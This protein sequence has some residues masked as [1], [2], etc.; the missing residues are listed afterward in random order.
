MKT[1]IELMKGDITKVA[2]DAIV[3]AA[4]TSL[5]GGGGVDGA[6]HRAAGPE[7]LAECRTLGGCETGQAKIT[8][9]Y[10]LAARYVIHAVGPVWHGGSRKEDE[11]L[12][13]CYRNALTL[14]KEH[15]LRSI[16]FPSIST[17]AYRFPIEKA[18]GIALST[19]KDILEKDPGAIQKVI[20]VLFSDQDLAVYTRSNKI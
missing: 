15:S 2:A 13:S 5:L 8:K 1:Q 4:N 18:A 17:G 19:V 11:L 10:R 6:I 14:A 12:A 3:N 20:F 16:A 7:L 9:G